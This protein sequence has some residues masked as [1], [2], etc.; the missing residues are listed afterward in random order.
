MNYVPVHAHLLPVIA[1]ALA[2]P[3]FLA[4]MTIWR[5]CRGQCGIT[6]AGFAFGKIL[7][8]VSFL[9]RSKNLRRLF[10]TSP[11]DLRHDATIGRATNGTIGHPSNRHASS[12]AI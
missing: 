1:A 3:F 6:G 7:A 2:L 4:R 8:L 12:F 10:I 11:N 9:Q 5:D